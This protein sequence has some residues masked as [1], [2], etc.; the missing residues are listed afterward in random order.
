MAESGAGLAPIGVVIITGLPG[1]GRTALLREIL[2]TLPSSVAPAVCVHHFAKAFGLETS[3]PLAPS[4]SS[5]SSC[6][7]TEDAGAPPTAMVIHYSE[8]YDFGSGCIC[9]SPD[10]D[11]AR[12]LREI[13]GASAVSADR[14]ARSRPSHLFIETT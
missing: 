5:S 4:F 12:V 2:C 3:S 1:S 6:G 8:V 7:G 11:L 13:A 14:T 9:C 10:G